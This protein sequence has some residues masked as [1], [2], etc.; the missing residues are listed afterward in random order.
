MEHPYV[1]ECSVIGVPDKL[2]GQAIKAYIVLKNGVE[3]SHALEKEIKEFCNSKLSDYKWVR[4][5]EFVSEMP[6]T[7]SGKVRKAEQRSTE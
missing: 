5:I 1:L 4:L 3:P 2:R 7:F 6:K